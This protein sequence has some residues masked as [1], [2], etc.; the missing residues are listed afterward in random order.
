MCLCTNVGKAVVLL[1]VKTEGFTACQFVPIHT[2]FFVL[3]CVL[4]QFS[5][6]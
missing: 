1:H 6:Q 4:G 5:V 3:V 2:L